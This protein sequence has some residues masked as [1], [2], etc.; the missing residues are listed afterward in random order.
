MRKNAE[1]FFSDPPKDRNNR[2][3]PPFLPPLVYLVVIFLIGLLLGNLLWLVSADVFAFG[4]EDKTVMFT[5]SEADTLKDVSQNLAES[6]LIRYPWLFRLYAK[7]SG[8]RFRPG[9]YALQARYDYH[10]LAKALSSGAV[11]HG[12]FHTHQGEKEILWQNWN[13]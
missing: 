6:G 5:V 7:L 13:C 1:E 9:E 8:Q 3:V 12:L 2:G 10:A 11:G 4:R